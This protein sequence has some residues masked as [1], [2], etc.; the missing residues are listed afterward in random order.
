[1]PLEKKEK[2]IRKLKSKEVSLRCME[3]DKTVLRI[4]IM[5]KANHQNKVNRNNQIL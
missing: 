4:K 2:D 3:K 1:V 5:K